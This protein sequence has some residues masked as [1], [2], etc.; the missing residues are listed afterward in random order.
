MLKTVIFEIWMRAN[1]GDFDEDFPEEES[2]PTTALSEV[3]Q[4]ALNNVSH[5]F[6]EGLETLNS[7]A[8]SNYEIAEDVHFAMQLGFP[9]L[10][11]FNE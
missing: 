3:A 6:C 7:F 10:S 5:Y 9:F 1:F 8:I 2:G 11:S 4:R